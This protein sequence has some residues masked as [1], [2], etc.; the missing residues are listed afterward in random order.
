M[1]RQIIWKKIESQCTQ[2]TIKFEIRNY[3]KIKRNVSEK[4]D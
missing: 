3:E 1:V 2:S 4:M